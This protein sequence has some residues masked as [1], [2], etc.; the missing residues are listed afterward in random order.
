MK[1]VLKEALYYNNTVTVGLLKN[2]LS[3][4]TAIEKK[5]RREMSDLV[6][7]S[8]EI[9]AFDPSEAAN[10]DPI[11]IPTAH[12][13]IKPQ[14]MVENIGGETAEEKTPEK[15]QEEIQMKAALDLKLFG[16]R[17]SDTGN[18][19]EKIYKIFHDPK[20]SKIK[21]K[22]CLTSI[23][24]TILP[25]LHC[26]ARVCS[27]SAK[28]LSPIPS[29]DY[30]HRNNETILK[31]EI[32]QSEKNT[33]NKN[34][35]INLIKLERVLLTVDIPKPFVSIGQTSAPAIK[36]KEKVSAKTKEPIEA[37][38]L[39]PP[40]NG[41]QYTPIETVELLQ[42]YPENSKKKAHIISHL[43][44]SELVPITRVGV[45]KLLRR[46]AAKEKIRKNWNRKSPLKL[47]AKAKAKKKAK[48]KKPTKASAK[49]AEVPPEA[50]DLPPPSNGYQ[51]SPIETVNLL[52]DYPD[53]SRKRSSMINHFVAKKLIPITRVGVYKLLRRYK[54]TNKIRENWCKT[55]RD[56]LLGDPE[57]DF[58]ANK[59][60]ANSGYVITS[61]DI[62]Q[63]IHEKRMREANETGAVPKLTKP[64]HTTIS[65]YKAAIANVEGINIAS[66]FQKTTP[67][68]TLKKVNG[69]C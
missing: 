34:K 32:R 49:K 7:P 10:L 19:I 37:P 14:E 15:T 51:Y 24:D 31:R 5:G 45:Y 29:L 59:L 68:R 12:D 8:C 54:L 50:A 6:A 13:A 48:K 39:P 69:I 64:S 46:Y 36:T 58:L 2:Q 40:S 60:K 22:L 23:E 20:S 35:S 33:S 21:K 1:S 9:P 30:V 41:T 55:G 44:D 65:N 62:V 57:I 52:K 28:I 26:A 63:M 17:L 66:V 4:F 67:I 61:D 53:N 3:L 42:G 56:K 25:F 38:N 47:I 16:A 18:E 11:E 43:V 27:D